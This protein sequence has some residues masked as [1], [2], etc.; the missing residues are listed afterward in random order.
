MM[1]LPALV[2]QANPATVPSPCINLCKMDPNTGWC[3]GC[4]RTISEIA[5]WGRLDDTN[6]QQILLRLPP[7]RALLPTPAPTAVSSPASLATP[8]ATPADPA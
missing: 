3:L 5:G 1:D 4:H 2:P 7:R 6:K 8:A